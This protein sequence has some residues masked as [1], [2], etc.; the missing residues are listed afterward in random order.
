MRGTEYTNRKHIGYFKDRIMQYQLGYDR[1]KDK[2]EKWTRYDG[3]ALEYGDGDLQFRSGKGDQDMY[4]L[5]VYR[6][7]LGN[8]GHYVDSVL[9]VGRLDQDF[10]VWDSNGKEITGGSDNWGAE[11]SVEYGRK[12]I[13]DENGWYIEPQ[14][15]LSYFHMFGDDYTTSGGVHVDQS[16]INSLVG[17]VGFN[18]GREIDDRKT[19]YIKLNAFHEFLGDYSMTLTDTVTG[20]RLRRD[21]SYGDS[22]FEYG[23]G[24]AIRT[25]EDTNVYF[26]FERS[27][28]GNVRKKWAWNAGIRWNF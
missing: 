11:A 21:G 26:D 18:L 25:G 15:Q 2:T 22:W 23:F 3:I 1:L 8:K 14:T 6:T 4:D 20:D 24:A 7:R 9:K 17:R 19:V 5:S 16:G 13:L 10:R 28:G 12:K 27:T